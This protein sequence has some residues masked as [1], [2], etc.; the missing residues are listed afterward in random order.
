M[1]TEAVTPAPSERA[2]YLLKI[3]IQRSENEVAVY[4]HMP[5]SV[6]KIGNDPVALGSILFIGA[7]LVFLLLLIHIAGK[8]WQAQG[9]FDHIDAESADQ[10]AV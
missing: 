4:A 7:I 1:S 9:R 2:Q 6:E 5:G 10:Q 8:R 3:L